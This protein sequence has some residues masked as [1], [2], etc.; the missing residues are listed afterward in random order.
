MFE[1]IKEITEWNMIGKQSNHTYLI[2]KK[3]R[4]LAFA[5]W[6][7]NAI[8]IL[9]SRPVIDKRYRKFIKSDHNELS[10]LIDSF[11][12]EYKEKESIKEK[13]KYDRL[14]KVK[15]GEKEYLVLLDKNKLFCNCT[16]F[17]YRGKCKHV[18]FVKT[19]FNL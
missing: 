12:K 6:H 4:I 1:I 11:K 5:K 3:G 13:P 17:N 14:F 18:E 16:G 8:D 7:S 15:S 2:D 9:K 19:K 10:K